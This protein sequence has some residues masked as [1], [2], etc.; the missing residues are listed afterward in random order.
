[1][2]KSFWAQFLTINLKFKLL[3]NYFKKCTDFPPNIRHFCQL[4]SF[5]RVVKIDSSWPTSSIAAA[6]TTVPFLFFPSSEH[7]TR[8]RERECGAVK[9]VSSWPTSSSRAAPQLF[10]LCQR[11]RTVQMCNNPSSWVRFFVTS[12]AASKSEYVFSGRPPPFRNL[13]RVQDR[14]FLCAC[15]CVSEGPAGKES[16]PPC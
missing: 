10:H 1:M 8:E 7:A 13:C 12:F 9:K 4:P 16:L 15:V 5:R 3:S 6:A 2:Y 11:L 14:D